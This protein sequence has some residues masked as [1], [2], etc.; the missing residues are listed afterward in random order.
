MNSAEELRTGVLVFEVLGSKLAGPGADVGAGAAIG[1]PIGTGAAV[2]F[3]LT[4]ILSFIPPK[5]YKR[6]QSAK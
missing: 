2:E 1:A 4:C 3:V 6:L 5:Q